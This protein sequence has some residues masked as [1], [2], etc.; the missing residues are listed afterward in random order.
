[1]VTALRRV[2]Q[3]Y[4]SGRPSIGKDRFVNRRFGLNVHVSAHEGR[5]PVEFVGCGTVSSRVVAGQRLRTHLALQKI[6]LR[7]PWNLER[8]VCLNDSRSSCAASAV[9]VTPGQAHRVRGNPSKREVADRGKPR[10]SGRD[11][12]NKQVV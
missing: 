5:V 7:Q 12:T 11:Q 9:I 8:G 3:K 2:E 4:Q 1:M 6:S 10:V